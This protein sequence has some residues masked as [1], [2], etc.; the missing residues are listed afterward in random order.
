MSDN[1]YL[2]GVQQ[3]LFSI[4]GDLDGGK[5]DEFQEREQFIGLKIGQ[6]E[7]LLS[8][9]T[10]HEIIMLAPITF[11]PHAPEYVDGVINLRGTIIPA[12]NMRKLMGVARG[13]PSGTSRIVITRFEG[14]TFGLL[15]DGITYVVSLLPSE[16]ENQSLPGKGTG[17]EF[18]GSISK[19]GNKIA[20]ILD[21]ARILKQVGGSLE[22]ETAD[23]DGAA[24]LESGAA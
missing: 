21:L 11:V 18:I 2:N 7:F 8:I 17:A 19:Q 12:I 6:E 20:G 13:K 9:T 10:I 16:I 22:D 3:G 4:H 1:I 23:S 5:E 15:V 24:D 14:V